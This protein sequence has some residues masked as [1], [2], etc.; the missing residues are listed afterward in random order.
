MGRI[1]YSDWQAIGPYFVK[2]FRGV[3]PSEVPETFT[4]EIVQVSLDYGISSQWK[5]SVHVFYL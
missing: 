5:E 2:P 3:L 1:P 4:T